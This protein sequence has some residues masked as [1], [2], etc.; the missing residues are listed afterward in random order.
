MDEISELRA[1]SQ[2][3]VSDRP[4]PKPAYWHADKPPDELDRDTGDGIEYGLAKPVLCC[5]AF[6]RNVAM[7]DEHVSALR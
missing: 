4:T 3:T 2:T 7:L 5:F 1:L 6:K